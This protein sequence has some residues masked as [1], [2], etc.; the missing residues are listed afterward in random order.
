MGDGCTL[1]ITT[2]EIQDQRNSNKVRAFGFKCLL[3]KLYIIVSIDQKPL[4]R[5]Q[6]IIK[7]EVLD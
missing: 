6:N 4:Q 2:T 5:C 7:N 3:F 1:L